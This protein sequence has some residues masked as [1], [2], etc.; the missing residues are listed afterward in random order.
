MSLPVVLLSGAD[1]DLQA[2]FNPFEDFVEGLGAEFVAA[3]DA[4]FSHI[5]VFPRI[6][7]PYEGGIRRQVMHRFPFGIFYEPQPSRILVFAILDLRQD[8]EQIRQRIRPR[9]EPP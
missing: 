7:P 5:A 6:A 8:E 4:H 9:T 2:A 3:V 1:Q